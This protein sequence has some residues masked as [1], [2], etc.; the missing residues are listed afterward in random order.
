MVIRKAVGDYRMCRSDADLSRV[1][2]LNSSDSKVSETVR[3]RVGSESYLLTSTGKR[4][5]RVQL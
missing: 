3:T 5:G 1:S 2:C 4:Q